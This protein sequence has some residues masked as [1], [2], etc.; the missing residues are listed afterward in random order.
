MA[1]L[2]IVIIGTKDQVYSILLKASVSA[3]ASS[4]LF[5]DLKLLSS[6]AVNCVVSQDEYSHLSGLLNPEASFNRA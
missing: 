3:V 4:R 6:S 2:Q 5:M 1:D